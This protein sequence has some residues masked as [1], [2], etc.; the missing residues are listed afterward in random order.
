MKARVG[1]IYFA[2]SK[3]RITWMN[4]KKSSSVQC[5]HLVMPKQIKPEK[6]VYL[7]P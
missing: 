7:F 6:S 3:E 4:L 2:K 5:S 1:E